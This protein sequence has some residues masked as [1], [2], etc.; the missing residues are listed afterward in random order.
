[1][2][3]LPVRKQLI[4]HTPSAPETPNAGSRRVG[5]AA[6]SVAQIAPGLSWPRRRLCVVGLSPCLF[7]VG[8]ALATMDRCAFS[9]LLHPTRRF[10][11]RRKRY[12]FVG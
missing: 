12:Q 6:G 3:E 10:A 5:N 9:R 2:R 4:R 8:I 7:W 1:M 11:L